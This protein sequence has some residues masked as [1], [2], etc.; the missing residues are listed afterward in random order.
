MSVVLGDK[1]QDEVTDY[2]GVATAR[3]ETLHGSVSVCLER[4]DGD[5]K[6]EEV[7]LPE[8]RLRPAEQT[9]KV[10]ICR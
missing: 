10:G 6:P 9:K 1:Y 5:G 2:V 8:V 3:T 4:A 7:W